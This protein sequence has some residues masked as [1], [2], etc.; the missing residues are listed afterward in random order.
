MWNLPGL[1]CTKSD[2]EMRERDAPPTISRDFAG[3]LDSIPTRV[4]D[5]PCGTAEFLDR[6]GPIIYRLNCAGRAHATRWQAD[7]LALVC[8]AVDARPAGGA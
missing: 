6:T 4:L 2:L 1:F 5:R 8:L 3:D 7:A